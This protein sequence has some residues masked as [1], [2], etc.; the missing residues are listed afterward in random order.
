MIYMQD[1]TAQRSTLLGAWEVVYY[2]CY[3]YIRKA[4][5]AG[6]ALVENN[7]SRF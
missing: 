4:R 1:M 3:D 5:S 7:S 6:P 2:K